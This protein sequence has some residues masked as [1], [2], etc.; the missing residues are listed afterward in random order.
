MTDKTDYIILASRSYRPTL[1]W[2]LTLNA[3][4]LPPAFFYALLTGHA[5][6]LMAMAGIYGAVLT[7]ALAMAGIRQSGK[8]KEMELIAQMNKQEESSWDRDI[9]MDRDYERDIRERDF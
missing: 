6:F 3:I 9:N 2:G 7:G 4:I 8:N 5:E 1:G